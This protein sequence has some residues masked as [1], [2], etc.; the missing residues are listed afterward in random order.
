MGRVKKWL[1]RS[2][3]KK[4]QWCALSVIRLR[5][6]IEFRREALITIQ[7]TVRMHLARRKYKPRYEMLMKINQLASQLQ[8]LGAMGKNL[9]SDKVILRH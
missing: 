1:I 2:Q 4:A 6:K 3:W 5:N 8:K 9:K 7:K